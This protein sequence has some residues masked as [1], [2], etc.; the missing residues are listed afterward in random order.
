MSKEITYIFQK[1]L[2]KSFSSSTPTAD[3]IKRSFLWLRLIPPLILTKVQIKIAIGKHR[4]AIPYPFI[5]LFWRMD[6]VVPNL[7]FVTFKGF[8]QKITSLKNNNQTKVMLSVGGPDFD[9]QL[10]SRLVNN[11]TNRQRFVNHT[12][13]YLKELNFDGLVSSA[14]WD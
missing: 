6:Q 10:F 13:P 9:D 8:Y 1:W 2:V 14:R 4:I 7:F 3:W 11:I 5:C 12:I